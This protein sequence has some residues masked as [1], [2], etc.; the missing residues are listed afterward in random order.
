MAT[1]AKATLELTV[2]SQNYE[3]GLAKARESAAQFAAAEEEIR[4]QS[5]KTEKQLNIEVAQ[6]KKVEAAY[7]KGLT[8]SEKTLK[9]QA[10]LE[11]QTSNSTKAA[12]LQQKALESLATKG[13]DQLRRE[14]ANAGRSLS[15]LFDEQNDVIKSTKGLTQE[16]KQQITVQA[17]QYE[18]AQDVIDA[19][20]SYKFNT[21]DAEKSTAHYKGTIDALNKRLGS[22]NAEGFDNSKKRLDSIEK[23]MTALNIP[24][25]DLV[26]SF[27]DMND[28]LEVMSKEGSVAEAELLKIGIAVGAVVA[29]A[30][31]AATGLAALGAA[32]VGIVAQSDEWNKEL[33]ALGLNLDGKATKAV[34]RHAASI[35][36]VTSIAKAA[37]VALASKFGPAVESAATR[38]V[39]LGLAS[40]DFINT[41]SDGMPII[42]AFSEVIARGLVGAIK[43]M[44]FPA[45]D[46]AMAIGLISD[47][48]GITDDKAISIKHRIDELTESLV[49]STTDG[50]KPIIR[51]GVEPL[52][53][54]TDDYMVRAAALIGQQVVVNAGF[55]DEAEAIKEVIEAIELMVPSVQ[56][57]TAKVMD[58]EQETFNFLDDLGEELFE[59]Q[60]DRTQKR[61]DTELAAMEKIQREEEMLAKARLSIVNSSAAAV[62]SIVNMV[63]GE[64]SKA[65]QTAFVAQQLAA[66]ATIAVDTAMGAQKAI[67]ATAP[68]VPLGLAIAGSII[69]SGVAAAATVAA[70]TIGSFSTPAI[71]GGGGGGDFSG[72]AGTAQGTAVN[73]TKNTDPQQSGGGNGPKNGGDSVPLTDGFV[74]QGMGGRNF[75]LTEG[76]T[77]IRGGALGQSSLGNPKLLDAI[78]R[79]TQ[80]QQRGNTLLQAIADKIGLSQHVASRNTPARAR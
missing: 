61:V 64:T 49:Q 9:Q 14:T 24:G 44:A 19:L 30:A 69:A 27:K 4:K 77:V 13:M 38:V 12:E 70:T 47:A 26:K 51:E 42:D 78:E 57:A 17:R 28:S 73:P 53:Y 55:R 50:W 40:I 80:V 8:T 66:L 33:E 10:K 31:V 2:L 5:D 56:S 32:I 25:A 65:A 45:L 3:A 63:A 60:E 36:A 41:F 62:V 68:N 59:G 34:N 15:M 76:D 20:E 71:G 23:A 48:M 72:G 39:A 54:A 21:D 58:V 79:L 67:T 11:R 18:S 75:Q 52:I 16:I 46:A 1:E 22:L 29:I 37:G 74:G 7:T 6:L 43:A 35:D